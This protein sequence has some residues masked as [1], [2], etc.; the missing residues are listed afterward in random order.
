M[1]AEAVRQYLID[2]YDFITPAMVASRGSGEIRPAVAD[3]S[4]ENKTLNRR[5]EFIVWEESFSLRRE[6]AHRQ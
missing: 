5:I 4:P 2:E 6:T 1:R 3:N